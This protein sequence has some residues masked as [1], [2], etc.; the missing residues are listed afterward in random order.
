MILDY[1][2]RAN[3]VEYLNLFIFYGFSGFTFL[4]NEDDNM[5]EIGNPTISPP[6]Y[7][8]GQIYLHINS[9]PNNIK[10]PIS[11]DQLMDI[12]KQCIDNNI[13]RANELQKCLIIKD[14]DN[15]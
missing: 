11:D 1:E 8:E 2:N 5:M 4:G 13:E 10:I 15:A 12:A 7:Y 3:L 9:Q 6:R 14:V